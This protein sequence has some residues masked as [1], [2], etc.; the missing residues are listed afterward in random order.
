MFFK[1]KKAQ[2]TVEYVTL[3]LITLGLFALLLNN[4]RGTFQ[5]YHEGMVTRVAG[6]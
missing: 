5:N 4:V 1:T 2:A 3:L 6:N